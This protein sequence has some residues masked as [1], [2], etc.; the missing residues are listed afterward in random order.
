T[1]KISSRMHFCCSLSTGRKRGQVAKL[2]EA[3]YFHHLALPYCRG[4][5]EQADCGC[6]GT[7][8][9]DYIAGLKPG[10]LFVVHCSISFILQIP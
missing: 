4:W 7:K 2:I 8:S 9:L 6:P 3:F 10:L 1:E 5:P